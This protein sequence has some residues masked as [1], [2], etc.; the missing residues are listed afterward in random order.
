LQLF[1]RILVSAG[2]DYS[3]LQARDGREAMQILQ[4]H[5]PAAIVL[6]LVMPNLNGFQ[7][8]D[9]RSQDARLE[10]IPVV[11]I[12][13][14]DRAGQPIVSRMLA[15]T[16]EQGISAQRLLTGI[17]ALSRILSPA[18]QVGDLSQLEKSS[19]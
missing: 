1:G 14:Q 19:G 4:E 11:I 16:Q 17:A 13:A 9:L 7:F 8:L 15:V 18:G 3:V 10:A 2:R 12:S 6:D 5:T